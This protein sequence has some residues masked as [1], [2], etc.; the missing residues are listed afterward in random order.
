VFPVG[1]TATGGG[2]RGVATAAAAVLSHDVDTWF[3]SKER[4]IVNWV[5]RIGAPVS[6]A[7]TDHTTFRVHGFSLF[8]D[9]H[10]WRLHWLLANGRYDRQDVEHMQEVVARNA[11]HRDRHRA[12]QTALREALLG[13]DHPYAQDSAA[14]LASNLAELRPPDLERF[15][16]TYYRANGATLILVGNF[17]PEAMMKTVTELF[18]PWPSEPPPALAPI[19]PMHPDP[20]PTW[21]AATDPQAVQVRITYAFAATSPRAS[22]GARRVVTEMVRDRVEQVRSRLGASYGI[23]TGY[24][25]TAAGDVLEV[26][27]L[28][29]AGRAGEAMRQLQADLGGLRA[30]DA[31]L[32]ADFV[33]GRRA[34]LTRALADP[35]RSS[36]AADRLERVAA[37]QLP[38]DA[39]ETLPA[40][41]AATTLDAARAVI[42]QDL[43]AARMVVV[44]DGRPQDTAAAFAAAGVTQFQT[45]AEEPAATHPEPA[46]R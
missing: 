30:G 15:R 13:R 31:A 20:G 11:A 17:D 43:Q 21:I 26:D 27:G 19:P 37:S 35:A 22:R 39:I 7:V 10:L 14:T 42:A 40:E 2:K 46:P 18:G 45:V 25:V 23:G 16:D 29:N 4:E 28:V 41:I 6:W 5:F 38:N 24:D 34:A 8:A 44:L 36:T 12:G 32:A 9:G 33:R 1:E 3:T